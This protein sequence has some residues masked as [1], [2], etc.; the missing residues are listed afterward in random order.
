LTSRLERVA[1]IAGVGIIVREASAGW[2]VFHGF[3]RKC[4]WTLPLATLQRVLDP[5]AGRPGLQ[6]LP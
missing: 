6:C 2:A 5:G 4:R 3:I 1:A